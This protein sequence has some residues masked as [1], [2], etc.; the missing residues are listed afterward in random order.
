MGRTYL[1]P[2][3]GA[4]RRTP[5][6][7]HKNDCGLKARV[8]RAYLA[9]ALAAVLST[10]SCTV[11]PDYS[12]P[13][14]PVS[15]NYSETWQHANPHDTLP[16]GDWWTTYHDPELNSLVAQVQLNNQN[17]AVS[18]AQFR[19]ACD[20]VKVERS[21][22]FPTITAS[23]AY[24]RT[25]SA[26]SGG[27]GGSSGGSSAKS[28]GSSSST[29]LMSSMTSP[30][31]STTSSGGGGGGISIGSSKGTGSQNSYSFPA[32][33]SYLV[34]V[35]GSVRRGLEYNK[36]SAQQA[37]ANFESAKL[38][39]QGELAQDYFSL[40]GQD[41]QQA[42]LTQTVAN[43]QKSL[44]LT[45]NKLN[46]GVATP[47]DISQARA[48]LDAAKAQLID[49][50][51]TRATYEHAIAI[52][53]GH[54][55][56]FVHVSKSPEQSDPPPIP[57]GVPSSLLERRPDIAASERNMAATNA[58]IGIDEA[59]Y[60]PTITIGANSSFSSIKLDELFSGPSLAWSLG[61][62]IAQTI[63]NGGKFHAQVL[64]AGATYDV[65][66]DT[67]RATVLTA[68]QQVE[69]A[70]STLRILDQE[71][72]A[73]NEAVSAAKQSLTIT[74]NEYN[75]GT[76]D[77]LT[78]ITA[79]NT[80][81]SDQLT[82]VNLHTRRL[83]ASVQLI[84]ALGGGWSASDIPTPYKI[85]SAAGTLMPTTNISY[86]IKPGAKPSPTPVPVMPPNAPPN[87]SPESKKPTD[88]QP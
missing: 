77:Y 74:Q 53:T 73:E 58:E 33:L 52:L 26:S 18:E 4:Q 22:L 62:V 72:L 7:A 11:G 25:Q 39:Y 2:G 59:A 23:P 84:E 8:N 78:V 61:P 40:R 34:D 31:S 85:E 67:Y 55:P 43:Y 35:W 44:D 42:L 46:S 37:Y 88:T 28:S 21:G 86:T 29:G 45:Q 14:A 15:P 69:D 10:T 70:L 49:T 57:I 68:F 12:R 80:L 24:S 82:Q 48:Q 3:E 36:A 83:V 19:E 41:A 13:T 20:A 30:T 16:K 50:E 63:F 9:L 32:S 1:S 6:W 76:I 17:L 66:V 60:Y 64:E 38:S 51:V 47:L 71:L 87:N 81:L 54:P 5:G 79:Q 27:G 65:S 75:A 56:A